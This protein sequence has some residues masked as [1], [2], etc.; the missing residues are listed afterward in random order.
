MKRS[1]VMTVAIIAVS[2]PPSFADGVNPHTHDNATGVNSG[3]VINVPA[4]AKDAVATVDRF[5]A[6]LTAGDLA[7]AGKE[8]DPKVLILE[9][10]GAERSAVE[11]LGGHAKGD[12]AFLKTAHQQLLRRSAH[13]SGDFAWVASESELHLQ[14]DGKPVTVL[15]TE[16][17]LLQRRAMAWK[18]VHIHW[19]SRKKDP[20]AAH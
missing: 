12:A 7:K 11:Y 3:A 6:A 4:A 20:A 8:L 13:V 14:K 10:G 9:S 1:I 17:M 15:S 5:S 16:T 2:I 19:S 18:I